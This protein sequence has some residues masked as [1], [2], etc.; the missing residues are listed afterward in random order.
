MSGHTCDKFSFLGSTPT[1]MTHSTIYSNQKNTV[2][3][4]RNPVN[5]GKPGYK[6]RQVW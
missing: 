6:P 4:G 1:L 2:S 5:H 3:L